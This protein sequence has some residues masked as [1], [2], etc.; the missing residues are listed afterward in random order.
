VGPELTGIESMFDAQ[1]LADAIIRPDA[2]I[3]HG[4]S[5]WQVRTTDG[6]VRYGLLLAENENT[7]V[8]KDANGQRHIIGRDRIASQTQLEGVSLM[9]GPDELQLSPQ[10]VADVVTFLRILDEE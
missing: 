10:D 7:I 6:A 2:G 8:L 3:A 4:Y 9:P 5:P 1:S